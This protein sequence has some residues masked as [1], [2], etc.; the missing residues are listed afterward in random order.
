MPQQERNNEV[1]ARTV[2]SQALGAE[3]RCHDDNS[4]AS[5]VDALIHYS[6]G[7]R[8]AMEVVA[9]HDDQFNS[10]WN[11]LEK[12]RH[13]LTV[14]G[15][16]SG[17]FVV[18]RHSANLRRV[19]DLLPEL[20]RELQAAGYDDLQPLQRAIQ[21]DLNER[22]ESLGVRMAYTVSHLPAGSVRLGPEGWSGL[23]GSVS[24][25]AWALSVLAKHPNKENKLLAHRG[26]SERHIFIWV[27]AGSNYAVQHCLEH[28]EGEPDV[29][30][31]EAPKLPQGVTHLWIAGGMSS[32]GVLAW[33]PERG[34]WRTAWTWPGQFDSSD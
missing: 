6:D 32:L 31:Q 7:R 34:W 1:I 14:S 11:A 24:L 26:V 22:A 20:L 12:R 29:I 27:T 23:V 28:R 3:V 10:M 21:S 17:W 5:M 19:A 16:H 4:Q 18:L 9:D 30:D 33:F 13:L 8:A 25:G 2:V 15:L